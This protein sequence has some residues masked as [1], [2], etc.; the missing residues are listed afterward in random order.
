MHV[1]CMGEIRVP[2]SCTEGL[3]C[4]Q[5]VGIGGSLILNSFKTGW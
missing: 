2:I 5:D 3:D 1:A 4:L